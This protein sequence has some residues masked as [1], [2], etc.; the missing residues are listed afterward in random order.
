MQLLVAGARDH[1]EVHSL[2][3]IDYIEVV[4]P[5]T[6][7]P[8]EEVGTRGAVM[9][10]AVFVDGVRLIDNTVLDLARDND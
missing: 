8:L 2:T 5:L 7:Q 9:A 4:D 6:L 10:L 1:I 3:D